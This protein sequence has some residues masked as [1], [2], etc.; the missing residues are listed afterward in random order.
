MKLP[1]VPLSL[2]VASGFIAV[3]ALGLSISYLNRDA[4]TPQQACER[5]CTASQRVGRL[6]P[7]YPPAQFAGTRAQSSPPMKC[8]CR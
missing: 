1:R 6:V 4:P 7:V 5:Q 8:E 2:V 3:I